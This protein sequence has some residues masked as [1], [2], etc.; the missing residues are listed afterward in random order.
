MVDAIQ[1][2]GERSGIS[3]NWVWTIWLFQRLA[4][5]HDINLYTAWKLGE[6]LSIELPQKLVIFAIE[7][8]DVLT[9]GEELTPKVEAVVPQVCE[10]VLNEL[11]GEH[12]G[13]EIPHGEHLASD[14]T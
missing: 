4:S 14:I 5:V 13:S 9:F 12:E 11:K 1:T 10:M 6:Q 7:V 2:K 3:I 8:E